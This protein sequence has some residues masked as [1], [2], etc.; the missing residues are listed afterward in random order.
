[1]DHEAQFNA[2]ELHL[3]CN[4]ELFQELEPLDWQSWNAIWYKDVSSWSRIK[5]SLLHNYPDDKQNRRSSYWEKIIF[6]VYDCLYMLSTVCS[7][8]KLTTSWSGCQ[9]QLNI[10]PWDQGSNLAGIAYIKHKRKQADNRNA[11]MPHYVICMASHMGKCPHLLVQICGPLPHTSIVFP[12][13]ENVAARLAILFCRGL[14]ARPYEKQVLNINL[15]WGW[16]SLDRFLLLGWEVFDLSWSFQ[17][18]WYPHWLIKLRIPWYGCLMPRIFSPLG[19][20]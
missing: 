6:S 19:I 20:S 3:I 2:A 4:E 14:I 15:A 10:S 1:M 13:C 7:L 9:L 5:G 18:Q 12:A 11:G 16:E 8:T 17:L